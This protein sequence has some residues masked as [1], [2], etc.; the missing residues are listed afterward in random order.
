MS[1]LF[2]L[3]VIYFIFYFFFGSREVYA[4]LYLKG[5]V[6]PPF[7]NASGLKLDGAPMLALAFRC[8]FH[9]NLLNIV[10]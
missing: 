2:L 1:S 8:L 9:L 6:L 3:L 10:F 5:Y 7:A 4:S